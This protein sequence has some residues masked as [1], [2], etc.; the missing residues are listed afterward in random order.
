M[1]Y[2]GFFVSDMGLAAMNNHLKMCAYGYTKD[3]QF[4]MRKQISPGNWLL[5]N[6]ECS[7]EGGPKSSKMGEY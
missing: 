3:S 1:C 5:V 2:F 6:S 4:R 7:L